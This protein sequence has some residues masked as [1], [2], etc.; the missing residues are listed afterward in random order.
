MIKEYFREKFLKDGIEIK[1]YK[2]YVPVL[3]LRFRGMKD[4]VKW[5]KR[6]GAFK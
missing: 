1:I 2:S 6:I 4:L 5:L 3:D